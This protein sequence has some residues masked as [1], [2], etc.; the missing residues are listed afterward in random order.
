MCKNAPE[1]IYELEHMGMPFD[2]NADGRIYQRPFGGMTKNF[3]ESS[4]SRT[5]AVADRTGHAMLHTLYQKNIE[6][7]TQFFIEWVGLDLI[8]DEDGDVL[9]M[10]CAWNCRQVIWASFMQRILFSQ[11]VGREEFFNQALMR[12]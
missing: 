8:R 11:Q 4:I 2:R 7:K 1:A 12:S 6:L 10:N 9:G 3:G 5:C